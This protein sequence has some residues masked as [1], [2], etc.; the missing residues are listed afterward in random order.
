[1]MCKIKYVVFVS[2]SVII[3]NSVKYGAKKITEFMVGLFCCVHDYVFK[4]NF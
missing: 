2:N 3:S 4:F 1:M